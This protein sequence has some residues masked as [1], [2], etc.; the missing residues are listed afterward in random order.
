MYFCL[1]CALVPITTIISF[2][3]IFLEFPYA[4]I[5]I[6]EN[7]LTITTLSFSKRCH[8][9]FPAP[10][11]QY[12]RL[13]WWSQACHS[14][15]WF[16]EPFLAGAI[17]VSLSY[18]T[19]QLSWGCFNYMLFKQMQW[20]TNGGDFSVV[21]LGFLPWDRQNEILTLTTGINYFF[22]LSSKRGDAGRPAW[23]CKGNER[24]RT[25]LL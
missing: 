8:T 15:K 11:W 24:S 22:H 21:G 5:N 6:F 25:L 12:L 18:W 23:A 13:K 1:L 16:V 7:I 17:T 3:L 20:Q 4:S 14:A 2:L 10:G 19:C 9:N